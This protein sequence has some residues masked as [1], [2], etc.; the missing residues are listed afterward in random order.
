MTESS[1]GENG[2]KARYNYCLI[3]PRGRPMYPMNE[4][5]LPSKTTSTKPQ[6]SSYDSGH[7]HSIE[8]WVEVRLMVDA[9]EEETDA[10]AKPRAFAA[11]A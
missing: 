1:G 3:L 9:A 6:L 5:E 2:D 8:H 7:E 10:I 4:F 11:R